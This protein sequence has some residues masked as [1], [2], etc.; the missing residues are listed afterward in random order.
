MNTLVDIKH[1]GLKSLTAF[2]KA[3]AKEGLIKIKE[4]KGGMT[5]TGTN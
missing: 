2:L 4:T 1:S 3:H 5:I